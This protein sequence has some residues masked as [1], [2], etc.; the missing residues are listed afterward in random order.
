MIQ[1]TEWNKKI[2]EF[3]KEN[4]ERQLYT[5][6]MKDDTL[7]EIT[8]MITRDKKIFL[9]GDS[10]RDFIQSFSKDSHFANDVSD[11]DDFKQANVILVKNLTLLTND[12]GFIEDLYTKYRTIQLPFVPN[13]FFSLKIEGA[14]VKNIMIWFHDSENPIEGINF[15]FSVNS[16]CFDLIEKRLIGPI[17]DVMSKRFDIVHKW[18]DHPYYAPQPLL[19]RLAK[20]WNQRYRPKDKRAFA[21]LFNKINGEY[22]YATSSIQETVNKAKIEIAIY[23]KD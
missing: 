6:C 4:W 20:I 19:Y 21:E 2:T 23:L 8:R 1:H 3:S 22:D 14:K 10:V 15:D 13:D 9:I 18:E 12:F 7:K 16:L 5:C 11:D 17:S